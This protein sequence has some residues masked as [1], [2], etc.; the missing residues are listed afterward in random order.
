MKNPS[1][2]KVYLSKELKE[3]NGHELWAYYEV[4]L[5]GAERRILGEYNSSLVKKGV[6]SYHQ[7]TTRLSTE[8][9]TEGLKYIY[10]LIWNYF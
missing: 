6:M 9:S 3:E 4:G 10:F 8:V 5:T 1:E 2:V 7:I